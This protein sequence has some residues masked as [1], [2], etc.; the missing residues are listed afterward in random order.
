MKLKHIY[1]IA[2]LCGLLFTSAACGDFLK[3]YSQNQA[4]VENV[5]NLD[6]LLIGEG[7][8]RGGLTSSYFKDDQS[9]GFWTNLSNTDPW[10]F[11]YIHLMDDD[12]EEFC[13][14]DSRRKFPIIFA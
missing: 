2:L 5:T 10:Y 14:W 6:E 1:Q 4:Y 7:Y 3:E 11:P 8:F 9:S 13:E 12:V